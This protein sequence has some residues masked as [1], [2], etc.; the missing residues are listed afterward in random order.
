MLFKKI[1]GMIQFSGYKSF[2][3][4]YDRYAIMG[5]E[6]QLDFAERVENLDWNVDLKA[7]KITFGEQ[8]TY[9]VQVLGSFSFESQTWLWSWA[10][11]AAN[12]PAKLL[13]QAKEFR[14]YGKN[15]KLMNSQNPI[16]NLL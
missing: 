16:G 2:S 9:P 3:S 5:F 6:K 10:N 1:F 8:E 13:E 11:Q 7:G 14:A 12:I 4:L 15:T